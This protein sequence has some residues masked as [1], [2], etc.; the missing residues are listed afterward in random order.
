MESFYRILKL[1]HIKLLPHFPTSAPGFSHGGY[2][3]QSPFL[4]P[5]SSAVPSA[6]STLSL[7][8]WLCSAHWSQLIDQLL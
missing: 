3:T 6:R 1:Q 2:T 4:L 5:S 7:P 8:S